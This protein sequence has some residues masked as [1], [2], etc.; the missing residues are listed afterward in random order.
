MKDIFN[1]AAGAAKFIKQQI[2]DLGEL[3]IIT[4]SGL[5][6]ILESFTIIKSIAFS[7]IPHLRDATF[8]KGEFLVLEHE[9]KRYCALNGRL[10]YYEGYSAAE[11]AFPIR[12]LFCL[13]VRKLIMTNATGGLQSHYEPG[14]I[15]M[16]KDHI[17]LL[18][19]NPLR[20]YNESN[21]G[22][23]F[24]DMSDAY[25]K[26]WRQTTLELA[27]SQNINLEQG[28]YACFQGP[29]LE[30]PAEYFYLNKIG[31]DL[32][33]MS[34]VPEVIAANHCGIKVLVFS[35]VTNVCMPIED[36]TPTTVESV[37]EVANRAIPVLKKLVFGSL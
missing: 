27:K 14:Q 10:H 30:T 2:D 19:D 11:V 26:E 9:G 13:G 29:S 28:I 33:G 21:F 8:H 32:V 15:V 25:N 16:V 36:I 24:P 35:V 5:N 1:K 31:A 37:I 18:P 17:N 20:G 22:P 7:R 12:I 3:C 23:R 4:G 6:P 34:T